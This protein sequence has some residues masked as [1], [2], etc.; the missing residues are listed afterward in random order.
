MLFLIACSQRNKTKNRQA[1]DI[2]GKKSLPATAPL[3]E[4]GLSIVARFFT[5]DKKILLYVKMIGSICKIT[6][7]L[8]PSTSRLEQSLCTG[9][10]IG[11]GDRN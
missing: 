4:I 6:C 7:N 2:C 10:I 1:Q 3:N 11:D 8:M 5:A 9:A